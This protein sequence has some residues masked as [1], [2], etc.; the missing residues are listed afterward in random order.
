[1]IVPRPVNRVARRAAFTLMEVMVVVAILVILASVASVAIF[2]SLDDANESA[3]KLQITSIETAVT[4]Y[5]LNPKHGVFPQTL[6]ELTTQSDAN[7]KAYL[8]QKDILDPWKQPF[9]YDPG[10]LSPTGKPHIF[11]TAPNGTVI[12]NF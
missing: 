2:R 12:S 5:R 11:T 9:Q 6:Q 4:S 8:E 3:A 10:T 1:M 7:T